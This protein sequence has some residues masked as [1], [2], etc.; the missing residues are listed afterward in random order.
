[1]KNDM[2]EFLGSR[3]P[4]PQE[5]RDR[6]NNALR[7][8]RTYSPSPR[9]NRDRF[10]DPSFFSRDRF[11]DPSH[12]S[13]STKASTQYSD[14][15]KTKLERAIREYGAD[16][17]VFYL[18]ND[19]RT[20]PL[21]SLEYLSE[22]FNEDTTF[23]ATT[24][25]SAFNKYDSFVSL[26]GFS[27]SGTRCLNFV[28]KYI[29]VGSS[30]SDQEVDELYKK[31][32][33]S[34][35]GRQTEE[36]EVLKAERKRL[37]RLGY[38][39]PGTYMFGLKDKDNLIGACMASI[40]VSMK[41]II[42]KNIVVDLPSGAGSADMIHIY[43]SFVDFVQKRLLGFPR[44]IRDFKLTIE[45]AFEGGADFIGRQG[46]EQYSLKLDDDADRKVS[47]TVNTNDDTRRIHLL[48]VTNAY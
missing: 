6:F 35:F 15:P 34:L 4:S 17:D 38:Q 44:K 23:V 32:Y 47:Y 22:F 36:P 33:A 7:F 37:M 25:A 3:S 27:L 11:E 42:I 12:F 31:A 8:S 48:V 20:L 14:V 10:E 40:N 28:P 45:Y 1:M 13:S 2:E 16:W 41:K 43:A 29:I 5:N 9:E 26:E 39:L 18:K 46:M 19:V 24:S 30:I 21:S